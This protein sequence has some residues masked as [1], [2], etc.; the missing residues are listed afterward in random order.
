MEIRREQSADVGASGTNL[1]PSSASSAT[2]NRVEGTAGV[3]TPPPGA[4]RLNGKLFPVA[5]VVLV[6][7]NQQGRV[8]NDILKHQFA[9]LIP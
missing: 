1:V 2:T 5:F 4:F 7:G 6:W 8:P 9:A 3:D